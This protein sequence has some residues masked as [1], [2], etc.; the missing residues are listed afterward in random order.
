MSGPL[1]TRH[2]EL[3]TISIVLGTFVSVL[4]ST[5]LSVPLH[6]I[7]HDLG[8]SIADATLLVTSQIVTFA[9]L[10]PI[11]GW[12]SH[13][14]GRK[15]LYL[16]AVAAIGVGGFVCMFAQNLGTLVA[17][18]IV[19]GAGAA[20]IVPLVQTLLPDMYEPERRALAL[21][22]WATANSL[23]QAL[24]PPLGGVLTTTFGWRA[25][26]APAPLIAAITCLLAARYVPAESGRV[27]SLQWRAAGSLTVGALLLQ[28]AF[29]AIPQ[30]GIRSP[31]VWALAIA[32]LLLLVDFGRAIR[33]AAVP[34]VAPQ[35]FREPSY[36]VSCIS[37][38]VGTICLGATLLATPL[39][40]ISI[41][42]FATMAAGFIAFA[43]PLAMAVVAP[44]TSSLVK[45]YGSVATLRVA[46]VVLALASA[47]TAL[48]VYGW[49]N[50]AALAAVLLLIG[51]GVAFTYTSSA[52]GAQ[53][54]DAGRFGAGV[55]LFNLLRIAGSGVGAATVA[56]VVQ[57]DPR[58][59]ATIFLL[60]GIVVACG[61]VGTLYCRSR[62]T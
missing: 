5:I 22:A 51:G 50:V 31:I 47:A 15:T 55:G 4:N 25:T 28:I 32:G 62:P 40:L 57:H 1:V 9:T 14:F 7:A 33:G 27:I 61:F 37:V 46:M 38:F 58:G 19:Q 59:F 43:L 2:R 39:Y 48:I 10:L 42:H 44:M 35:A 20:A 24:G 11:C 56:I 13:R 60:I 6:D 52:V 26:F 18:R 8:I 34:F 16:V 49:G 53:Q 41:R 12:L 29:V 17:M 45:R 36:V 3:A 21:S 30:L 23:G 54:T